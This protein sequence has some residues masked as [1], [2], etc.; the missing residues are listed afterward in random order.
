M[1]KKKNLFDPALVERG[2]A[3][4]RSFW[5][6][7]KKFIA[8]GNVLDLAVAVVISTA[9]GKITTSL[10]NNIIMPFVS[11]LIGGIN[12]TD[13]KWVIRPAVEAVTD[14]ATG[15]VLVPA[16]AE[17]ALEYGIFIQNILNFLIIAFSVFVFVRLIAGAEKRLRAKETAAQA[18][19]KAAADA[20]AARVA[21]EQEKT[22]AQAAAEAAEKQAE[23]DAFEQSVK[24]AILDIRDHLQKN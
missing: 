14:P 10:V 16:R 17:T 12:V 3:A 7:F 9:F 8:K 2:K 15:A 5:S 1:R 23:R 18:E 13:W 21:A 6:D 24:Q 11:L 20:E 19:A 4:R 22:T